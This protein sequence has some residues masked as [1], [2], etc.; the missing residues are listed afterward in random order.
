[1]RRT[2]VRVWLAAACLLAG[3]ATGAGAHA[4]GAAQASRA[5]G[6]DAG[7]DRHPA[8]R[9]LDPD[10]QLDYAGGCAAGLA[11]GQGVAR[12]ADG[13]WYRGGF[14]AGM[15]SG[16]GVKIYPNGDAYAGGW[17][18]DRREGEGRYEY[19][20]RS[21]WRG[22]VY[23]GGWRADRQHGRGVYIF[24]PSG[25]RFEAD[26]VDGATKT[27]GTAT[28]TR[29]KRAF[30][31]LA[32]VIGRVGARVCSVTTQG[33]APERIARGEVVDVLSDRLLVRI[34]SAEVLARSPDPGLNP[35]WE[36]LTEWLPCP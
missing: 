20:P 6:G 22:D 15:K 28:V 1:M 16:H 34:D 9:V 13:A 18:A 33:A 4:E 2:C 26:W 14:E 31:V 25:D 10:L 27:V 11:Q 23:Q 36:V 8:C 30:E 19:G 17:R 21:P 24:Y 29:R 3:A 5:A 32:P 12:G 7:A 35:R